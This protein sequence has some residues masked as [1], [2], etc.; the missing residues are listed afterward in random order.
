LLHSDRL[1]RAV[2][3]ITAA[4]FV[5]IAARANLQP[6]FAHLG[7]HLDGVDALNEFRAI[8]LGLWLAQAALLVIATRR[9]R[10]PILGDLGALLI[11]GQVFGRL[12]SL[13]VDGMPGPS[14][15]AIGTLELVGGVVILLVRPA[16]SARA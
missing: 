5:L 14:I 7:K 4:V 16:A 10:E 8:Y 6:R 12:V 2:L 15:W 13:V 9:V 11:L 3:L 1:R